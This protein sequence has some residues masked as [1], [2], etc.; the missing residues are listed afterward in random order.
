M[1]CTLSTHSAP[2]PH[3]LPSPHATSQ[4]NVESVEGLRT[5]CF[6]NC[7]LGVPPSVFREFLE[8][9]AV[10]KYDR[11]SLK[12]FI[13]CTA[14]LEYCPDPRCKVIAFSPA[15]KTD[16]FSEVPC[17][18]GT[19]WCFNCRQEDHRPASCTYVKAWDSKS[20]DTDLTEM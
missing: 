2:S 10:E 8:P 12:S 13:E 7:N 16:T 14:R 5:T 4:V 19:K 18:C 20:N 17:A 9:G 6:E 1:P 15:G 11:W 3:Y